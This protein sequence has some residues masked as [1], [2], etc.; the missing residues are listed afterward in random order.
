[1]ALRLR[2]L[3]SKAAVL[4]E[5]G[6]RVFGVHGGRVGRGADNDWSLPDPERYLSGHHARIEYRAGTWYLVDTSSNGVFVNDATTPIGRD[7]AHAVS[8][9]D[10][11]RMGEYSFLI[12]VSPNNDFPP[13][14]DTA[15][16]PDSVSRRDFSLATS[17][18]LGADI[19]IN[20][21]IASPVPPPDSAAEA[22][23]ARTIGGSTTA[24]P[25]RVLGER[26][27]A[28]L[29]VET[30]T[31][32]P[33]TGPTAA[34]ALH[35][36]CR[37]AGLDPS[38][39]SG[40]ATSMM[41]LAGQLVREFALGLIAGLQ[42]RGQQTS[43][44]RLEDT[45]MSL[46]EQNPFR[47]TASVDESLMRLFAPRSSRFLPPVE[48]VR[49]SFAD[50]R[51]HDEATQ[52]A[53]QDGLAEYLKRFAPKQLELQFSETL[54]HSKVLT[55]DPEERFWEMYG[56]MYRVLTQMSADGLPHAFA[57]DFARAYETANA[58]LTDAAKRPP[59]ST[60][61]AARS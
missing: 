20:R 47:M 55:E 35:A 41:T 42:Y 59:L 11:V 16:V 9:G 4:G 52:M 10:R 13:D 5:H 54:T 23:H 37:G 43:R 51:R 2:V 40:Q 39:L 56:D 32:R 34:G 6:T 53:L 15:A 38:I 49:S 30:I 61:G 21:L 8:T 45:S 26:A 46:A 58:E 7:N 22:A 12:T 17:G 36:F 33:D 48:A 25:T 19:D 29:G 3:G 14:A 31:S 50:L 1:M 60:P 18:D 28:R 57:E 24:A 27:A 44:L